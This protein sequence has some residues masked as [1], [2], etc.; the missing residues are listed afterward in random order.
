M[1]QHSV[2]LQPSGHVFQVDAGETVLE[3]ALRQGYVLPYGCKNGACED[4]YCELPRTGSAAPQV[5]QQEPELRNQRGVIRDGCG[6][7]SSDP[8]S[9]F[10]MLL[11]A[12]FVLAARRRFR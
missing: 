4:G 11:L 12:L 5:K 9:T 2:T 3:A 8:S 1:S 10:G 6:C 7:K